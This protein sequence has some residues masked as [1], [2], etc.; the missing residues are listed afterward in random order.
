RAR[1]RATRRG[2]TGARRRPRSR[3]LS[4]SPRCR[5]FRDSSPD[6]NGRASRP[7]PAARVRR[8]PSAG[9]KSG[10]LARGRSVGVYHPDFHP[11][12]PVALKGEALPVGEPA[13]RLVQVR[14]LVEG[15]LFALARLRV[16]DPDVARRGVALAGAGEE[17][18]P[19]AIR[20]PGGALRLTLRLG[21]AGPTA[22]PR[23]PRGG[24][25]GGGPPPAGPPP[26]GGGLPRGG[27]PP[28]GS[29]RP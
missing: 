14:A 25:G 9:G 6:A 28:R 21:Q 12:G 29:A 11:T 16:H 22:P 24:G 19:P 4:G 18:D 1:R 26:R 2:S 23:P 13:G 3:R 15:D 10:D 17:G 5:R 27:R 8:R 20:R 7:A